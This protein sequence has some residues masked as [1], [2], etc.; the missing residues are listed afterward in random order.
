MTDTVKSRLLHKRR[1]DIDAVGSLEQRERV[2]R[3]R[4]IFAASCKRFD[5][6][7]VVAAAGNDVADATARV[8]H[9]AAEPR[10]D[11]HVEMGHSLARGRSS[12]E[13]D[14]EAVRVQLLVQLLLDDVDEVENRDPF[15][16][17]GAKPVGNDATSDDEG[18]TWRHRKPISECKG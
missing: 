11:V 10:D 18:V 12:V 7:Q 3:E 2:P 5:T 17:R 14:I 1:E 9:V 16:V 15:R 13:T 8:I 4:F 6:S